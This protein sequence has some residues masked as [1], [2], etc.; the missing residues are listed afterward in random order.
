MNIECE[1]CCVE[2]GRGKRDGQRRTRCKHCG[3]LVC[4]WCL[5]HVHNGMFIAPEKTKT[6]RK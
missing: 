4:G 6:V 3:L 2:I 5:H 1:D